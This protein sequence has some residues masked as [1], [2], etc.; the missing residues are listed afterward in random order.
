MKITISGIGGVGKGTTAKLLTKKL[1]Y[2][3]MS[4]GDFFRQMAKDLNMNIYQF[5]QFVRKN[6]DYDERLDKIQ[7]EF[8]KNNNDFVLESRIGWYFVPD[9]FKIKLICEENERIKRIS[10][11]DGGDLEKIKKEEDKR[12]TSA[13]ERYKKL[14]GI[15]DFRNNSHFDL[16]V[17]TTENSPEEIVQIILDEMKKLER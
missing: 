9:S 5:D 14:Y 17:N 15:E 13:N 6:P 8:G 16:I 11:R 3:K 4:G 12:L 10:Q 2:Q 1:G 7:E